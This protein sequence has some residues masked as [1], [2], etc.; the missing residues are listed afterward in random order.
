MSL[1]INT[2]P[3][4]YSNAAIWNVTTSLTEG[5]SYQNLRIRAILYHNGIALASKVQRKGLADF[6]FS[7]ILKTLC[8]PYRTAMGASNSMNTG[9]AASL[10]SNKI[11][12]WTNDGSIPWDTFTN[13]GATVNSLI[14]SGNIAKAY[15]NNFSVTKGKKY[16]LTW[17]SLTVNSGIRPRVEFE[18]VS[19]EGNKYEL[20]E[21]TAAEV[22]VFTAPADSA[23]A[24]VQL[25]ADDTDSVN[26]S[27]WALKCYEHPSD[28]EDTPMSAHYYILFSEMYENASDV[29][30]TGDQ[31]YGDSRMFFN[32]EGTFDDYVCD[33]ATK[34]LLT[35]RPTAL[36]HYQN[37][38]ASN[39]GEIQINFI[40]KLN[41]VYF[42]I[43]VDGG[44][45]VRV[46]KYNIAGY[47]AIILNYQSGYP[48]AGEIWE[49][50]MEKTGAVEISD[51]YTVKMTTR[52]FDSNEHIQLEWGNRLGGNETLIFLAGHKEEK[53][54]ERTI[55]RNEDMKRR[56][57]QAIRITKKTLYSEFLP[58]E[59]MTAIADAMSSKIVYKVEL[60]TRT[61]VFV[62]S[63]R[64]T[65]HKNGDL[66]MAEIQIEE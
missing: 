4:I 18:V 3:D 59:I 1:T 37:P 2:K 6:D 9:Y 23:A 44:A 17:T 38:S 64:M 16:C 40:C 58:R 10:P 55:Y 15:S 66:M 61:E 48:A 24:N 47:G 35:Q 33:G 28:L 39:Q 49:L 50:T 25:W 45:P 7:E 26:I 57:A 43:V 29:T 34:K 63:R 42:K 20:E 32:L 30:T 65:T 12:G 51:T 46:D 36:S 27:T 11:T 5:A 62:A 19:A 21:D 41:R 14:N 22:F 31:D 56:L 54:P 13:T 60:T 52:S 53:N 8:T